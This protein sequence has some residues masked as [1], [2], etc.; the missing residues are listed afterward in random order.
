M[1]VVEFKDI[2]FDLLEFW[3]RVFRGGYF[4]Y[5]LIW[6]VQVSKW[7]WSTNFY[8]FYSVTTKSIEHF[9]KFSLRTVLKPR[10]AMSNRNETLFFIKRIQIARFKV[11]D[12]R[13]TEIFSKEVIRWKHGQGYLST[14]Q[15]HPIDEIG[16]LMTPLF[17]MS[18]NLQKLTSNNIKM[19]KHFHS[20]DLRS[21]QFSARFNPNILLN[22]LF[23][24][25]SEFKCGK[26]QSSF[27]YRI[28]N[29]FKALWES[30][31][32]RKIYLLWCY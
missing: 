5:V 1:K 18:I 7:L 17:V 6:K 10:K 24:F 15:C 4:R 29:T 13:Y 21:R 22:W 32:N 20:I 25:R 31:I 19:W 9:H 2:Q 12:R 3:Q 27:F 8:I 23:V 14:L 11:N 28:L 16:L 26:I 30:S